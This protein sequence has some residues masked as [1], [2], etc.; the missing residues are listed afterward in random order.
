MTLADVKAFLRIDST[1]DDTNL[2]ALMG[3]ALSH[4]RSA[5]TGFDQMYGADADFTNLADMI[6]KL[7]INEL[8]DHPTM[9][10]DGAQDYSYTIRSMITQLQTWTVSET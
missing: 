3:V 2:T 9:A 1:D 10:H 4:V 5:V 8:Y 7:M 6:Q